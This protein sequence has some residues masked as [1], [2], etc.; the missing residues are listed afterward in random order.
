MADTD[1]GW[2]FYP[3][4][5]FAELE[6]GSLALDLTVPATA[7]PPPLVVWI[8][9]G[10]WRQGSRQRNRLG[11]LPAHG[12]A[13]ASISY[14]LTDRAIFPAQ[15]HDCKGAVRWLRS[16]AAT[17]GYDGERLAAAGGSAGAQL[18]MLLA[19]TAGVAELEGSVGGNEGVSAAVQAAANYF[20]PSDFLLRARTQPGTATTPERGSFLLL[21]GAGRGHIDMALARLAS[22][23]FHVDGDSAPLISFQGLADQTVLP[24]QAERIA[25]AYRQHGRPHE[26][27][28]APGLAHG[29]EPLFAGEYR[30]ILL[31]F[32]HTHL[33]A[34]PEAF[35]GRPQH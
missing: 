32:L 35:S 6:G 11:W 16:Q 9:G 22:P 26:L 19:T 1:S 29:A 25:A 10:G 21:G 23:A 24:G 15:I 27:H 12:F 14:R 7:S 20:G 3:D 30:A 18:A 31:R 28:L 13:V 17:Y 33:P 8:H 4:L 2:H 5:V 34:G